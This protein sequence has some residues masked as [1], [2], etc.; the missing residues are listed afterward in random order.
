M[1]STKLG[2]TVDLLEGREVLQGD[3]DGIVQWAEA[4]HMRFNVA[5]C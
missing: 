3:L 5:N 4:S 2:K 1:Y